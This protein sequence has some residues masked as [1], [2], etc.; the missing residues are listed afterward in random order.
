MALIAGIVIVVAI[1]TLFGALALR[2][3]V[4][5]RDSRVDSY[6]PTTRAGMR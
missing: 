5:S 1:L 2:W 3:G 4:D 6:T